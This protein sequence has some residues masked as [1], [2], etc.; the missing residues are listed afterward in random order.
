MLVAVQIQI[1]CGKRGI[2]LNVIGKFDDV[3]LEA[4]ARG[5]FLHGLEYLGMRPGSH[6]D[7]Q[8]FILTQR[9]MGRKR[10]QGKYGRQTTNDLGYQHVSSFKSHQRIKNQRWLMRCARR[11]PAD[12]MNCTSTISTRTTKAM[13]SGRKRW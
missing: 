2:G 1:A 3:D 8:R 5:N 13:T 7:A 10:G 6:A 9:R 4:I 12:W 11:S